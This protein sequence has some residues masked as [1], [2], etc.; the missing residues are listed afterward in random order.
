MAA[1]ADPTPDRVA[2]V[3]PGIPEVP[4]GLRLV[5]RA[6]GLISTCL[7]AA[8]LAIICYDV[9]LRYAFNAPTTWANELSVYLLAG[10]TFLGLAH[11]HA[12]RAHVRVDIVLDRL[13]ASLRHAVSLAVAAR[14]PALLHRRR[15]LARSLPHDLRAGGMQRIERGRRSGSGGR[16]NRG[17]SGE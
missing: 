6:S 17:D 9:L 3:A 13:P 1:R 11:A 16:E 2:G 10:I 14:V 12:E 7:V 4:V 15:V 8:M 5:A